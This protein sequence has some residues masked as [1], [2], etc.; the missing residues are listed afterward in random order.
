MPCFGD[1]LLYNQKQTNLWKRQ[2]FEVG[3]KEV[4]QFSKSKLKDSE[5][6][7]KSKII[8]LMLRLKQANKRMLKMLRS[9]QTI[10]KDSPTREH[11]I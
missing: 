1:N 4:L 5:L 10:E 8:N 3:K 6:N 9:R 11:E 7:K 2:K